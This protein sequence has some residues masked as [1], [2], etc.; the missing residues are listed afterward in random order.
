MVRPAKLPASTITGVAVGGITV[1]SPLYQRLRE[2]ADAGESRDA[3]AQLA[4]DR[5]AGIAASAL[6]VTP[7]IARLDEAEG[8]VDLDQIAH[9]VYGRSLTDLVAS[10]EFRAAET[11]AADSLVAGALL[12][13]EGDES[14]TR[15]L[16]AIALAR[17]TAEDRAP[18]EP[19]SAFL[20]RT[21]V[22][23]PELV[24]REPGPVTAPAVQEAPERSWLTDLDTAHREA[25]ALVL[26]DRFRA[27]PPEPTPGPDMPGMPTR[28]TSSRGLQLTSDALAALS[29]STREVAER[30]GFAR[31]TVD[32]VRAVALIE[33]AMQSAGVRTAGAVVSFTGGAVDVA[34][35]QEE[36]TIQAVPPAGSFQAGVADLLVLRQKIKAYE[37]GEFA[38]IENVMSG[39]TR[40]R[41]T[42]R[43]SQI[44]Q[45]T[46]TE[47]ESE[48]EK[49]RDLSSTQRNELQNEAQKTVKSAT[50][51]EAG[52]QV[53]G[54][55]G[56][57]V[58]FT[59]SLKAGFSSSTEEAQRKASSFSQE[60]T[61]RTVEKVRESVRSLVRTR[62]LEEF[63]ETNGHAFTNSNP[64]KH[65][66][67]IYRWLNKIYDAQ[68]FN[69]GQRMMFDF[70]VPEPAAYFLHALVENPPKNSDLVKPQP[71]DFFGQALKP[72][73]LTRTN[74]HDYVARYR[75]ANVP[76][77]LPQFQT[78][79]FFEKQDG[80][81]AGNF[82]RAGKLDIPTGYQTFE[83]TASANI[84]FPDDGKHHDFDV[85]IGGAF[86]DFANVAGPQT[87][88]IMLHQKEI[89]IAL[90]LLHVES[91][92][93][94]VDVRCSLT[95]EGF[96]RWQQ[97]VYDTIIQAYQQQLAEFQDRQAQ[98]QLQ[99]G[100]KVFGNNPLVNVRI[101]RDELKR[102]LIMMLTGN[103]DLDLDSFQA[104]TPDPRLN[105]AKAYDNG[106]FIRFFE[107]AFE[108][109]NIL[110][111]CYPHFWGRRARWVNALNLSDPD[112][113]FAAFLRAGAARV[114]V[115]VRPGFEAAVAYYAQ[116]GVIWD[117]ND[118][119]AVND[120]LYLPI[121]KEITDNLGKLDA[122]V[123]YPANSKPWEVAVPTDLV[124]VQ[125]VDEVPPLRDA[126][127][128]KPVNL[129]ITDAAAQE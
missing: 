42:R 102:W 37:L 112:P 49:E 3:L 63:E 11:R 19:V 123:P 61:Q 75:V 87:Q 45:I 8:E 81:D 50:E 82:G 30:L 98:A 20:A 22:T 127:S 60:V 91:F 110:Y 5:R 89:S 126:L 55:Y 107:N 128:N 53:S 12:G 9:D 62:T 78:V 129:A 31:D 51:I 41:N 70:V 4:R 122:G 119:P 58:S 44:E 21:P 47:T 73:H 97:Q 96:T 104:G 16:K 100:S 90:L 57:A 86:F 33:A 71:P 6:D 103:A 79:T 83:A 115:P 34:K 7:L 114:Q 35:F 118:V 120:Q 113:D 111:V 69:Y 124:L 72:S 92:T 14:D 67:G 93:L 23:L 116:T 36:M 54:S 84:T 85:M 32:P 39:E 24:V 125:S 29:P 46:E 65:I 56:P 109:N 101:V 1:E 48:T 121:V 108:W 52:L 76:A 74:Y 64:L 15:A 106:K 2:V 88:P 38:H 77:P 25:A 40:E 80:G 117:G 43:L 28:R 105:L 66:R 68:V 18:D 10:E 59:A 13:E 17:A 26:D 99:Q 27:D 95:D 94:G